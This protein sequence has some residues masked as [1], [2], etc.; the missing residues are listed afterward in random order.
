MAVEEEGWR[1]CTHCRPKLFSVRNALM[2]ANCLASE[3]VL[4]P[5]VG[6]KAAL[7]SY[8]DSNVRRSKWRPKLPC[9]CTHQIYPAVMTYL[10]E[11]G[12]FPESS[13]NLGLL[14]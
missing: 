2:S 10:G 5:L 6:W 12:Q 1:T 7:R 4:E 8:A 13:G 9:R 3:G 14:P 11:S